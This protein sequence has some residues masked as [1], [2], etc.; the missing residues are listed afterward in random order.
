[1]NLNIFSIEVRARC[2]KIEWMNDE[3]N[4][5]INFKIAPK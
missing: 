5:L 4:K 1:M 3:K 2:F